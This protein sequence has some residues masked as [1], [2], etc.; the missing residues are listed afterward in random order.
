MSRCVFQLGVGIVLLAGAFLVTDGLFY[1]PGVTQANVRRI[2]LGMTEPEVEGI[3]GGSAAGGYVSQPT[4]RTRIWSGVDGLA[5]VRFGQH[6]RVNRRVF[7]PDR[8]RPPG[9]LRQFFSRLGLR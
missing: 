3:L 9:H 2:R 5:V 4:S 7:I 8:S 1:Q 6:D